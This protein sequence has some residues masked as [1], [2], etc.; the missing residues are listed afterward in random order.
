MENVDEQ[1]Y[2]SEIRMALLRALAQTPKRQREVLQL[3][4]Y[5]KLILVEAAEMMGVL[6]RSAR[7]H[8]ERWEKRL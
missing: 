4:C 1:V 7:S 6:L 5:H 2:R 8:F 3:V